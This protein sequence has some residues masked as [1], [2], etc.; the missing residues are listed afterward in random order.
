M[1][2][3]R[4]NCVYLQAVKVL[5]GDPQFPIVTIMSMDPEQ[6]AKSF[7]RVGPECGH[8][9]IKQMLNMRFY[10][11]DSSQHDVGRYYNDRGDVLGLIRAHHTPVSSRCYCQC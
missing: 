5:F 2:P 8:T 3:V 6:V 11:P 10:L 1:D 4:L 9:L 7:N